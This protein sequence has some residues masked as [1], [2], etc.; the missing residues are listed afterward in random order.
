MNLFVHSGIFHLDDVLC[1]VMFLEINKGKIHTLFL[2]YFLLEIQNYINM[3][4]REQIKE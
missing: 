4:I 2:A 3:Y 1:A